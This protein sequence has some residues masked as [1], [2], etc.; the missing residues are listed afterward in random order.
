MSFTQAM[1]ADPQQAPSKSVPHVVFGTH[2]AIL[3]AIRT[4]AITLA[5]WRRRTPESFAGWIANVDLGAIEDLRFETSVN[6]LQD[7]VRDG[8]REAGYPEHLAR[9][10]LTDD[11]AAL[12][13]Q[14]AKIAEEDHVV[15]RL[16]VVEDDACRR[17]H[18]DYVTAR[19]IT[20]Y[21]G[22]GTQWLG[23]TDAAAHD[24]GAPSS[25][26]AI[27]RVSTG[28]VG[29]FKGRLWAPDTA[30]IHRSPPI[31]ASGTRRL[32]LVINPGREERVSQARQDTP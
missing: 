2:P 23:Q 3:S 17:F 8:L 24:A 4:P 11:I 27:N 10:A 15:I 20:T 30:I 7:D 25:A 18:A 19:L 5:I 9:E 13:R 28:H 1:A 16:E 32:V 14:L 26:L 22:P 31:A 29:L 6:M 21:A 12:A